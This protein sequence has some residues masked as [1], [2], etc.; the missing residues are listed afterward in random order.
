[1]AEETKEA[2]KK[3]AKLPIVL[4]LLLVLGGGGFFMMKGKTTAS[5]GAV[6]P[7]L[8]QAVKLDEFLV[9]LRDR[10][11]YLRADLELQF[12]ETDRSGDPIDVKHTLENTLGQVRSAII[13]RL[14]SKRESEMETSEGL[15]QLK[16][17][18]AADVN[19]VLNG[20]H[21]SGD[22]T[23]TSDKK[24]S[25]GADRGASPDWDSAEGPVLKVNFHSFATQ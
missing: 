2:P 15:L 4:A 10:G 13:L 18:L 24:D 25:K 22:A 20:G 16:R 8:G 23:V 21:K 1:M 7:K 12:S 11:V 9:N 3:T 19:K 5:K 17:E 6:K 14:R